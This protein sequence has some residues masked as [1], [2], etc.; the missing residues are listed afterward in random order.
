VTVV[1]VKE[2]NTT[3]ENTKEQNTS[4]KEENAKAQNEVVKSAMKSMCEE[5]VK[6]VCDATEN[7]G[8]TCGEWLIL[9]ASSAV[10]GIIACCC[11][12]CCCGAPATCF[13]RR[14]R[15]LLLCCSPC[16][17]L[18]CPGWATHPDSYEKEREGAA[19]IKIQKRLRGMLARRKTAEIWVQK[20]QEQKLHGAVSDYL[21]A[22]IQARVQPD[23]SAATL[24]SRSRTPPSRTEHADEGNEA[25][26]TE[27]ADEG[28]EEGNQA[29]TVR[30]A[31]NMHISESGEEGT[32]ER[33]KF[34]T[35]LLRELAQA[36]GVKEQFLDVKRISAG[37]IIVDVDICADP[38]LDA[39]SHCPRNVAADLENQAQD[40]Q[41]QLRS[42]TL[43]ARL[44]SISI[45]EQCRSEA[46]LQQLLQ[47]QQQVAPII[48]TT[49][50]A[51]KSHQ[52]RSTRAPGQS[53]AKALARSRSL[54]LSL[55]PANPPKE[56]NGK[57]AQRRSKGSQSSTVRIS[58]IQDTEPEPLRLIPNREIIARRLQALREA[59]KQQEGEINKDSDDSASLLP[60]IQLVQAPDAHQTVPE[61]ERRAKI[62][63]SAGNNKD[64]SS[65]VADTRRLSLDF[66]ESQEPHSTLEGSEKRASP[67]ALRAS[68]S[69]VTYKLRV[70]RFVDCVTSGKRVSSSQIKA[71]PSE[72]SA[73]PSPTNTS[74]GDRK[75]LTAS[76]AKTPRQRVKGGHEE[77]LASP[78]GASTNL[79]EEF[80]LT[81]E[82]LGDTCA[83]I[84]AVCIGE[85][86]VCL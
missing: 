26:R 48:A 20:M 77:G 47:E 56:T 79:F 21:V 41:S 40:E 63:S 10:V 62:P 66:L 39:D 2:Q 72:K 43:M 80:D 55:L 25:G 7:W 51:A 86:C 29:V 67:S 50:A 61:G 22:E 58:V 65:A 75:P 36:S 5:C 15:Q 33:A 24:R 53:S 46:I 44:V 35:S 45:V 59:K 6:T 84:C 27:H 42:G 12:C 81:G 3:E 30:I 37:S 31:L 8:W 76:D 71:S 85:Y 16:C 64:M 32:Y 60:K 73:S 52:R 19:A 18:C 68:P 74:L 57:G 17:R 82:K 4:A 14:R 49:N 70:P 23:A 11:C 9:A 83:W 54:Y 38:N 13:Y 78:Q 69:D 1:S 28:K 34:K